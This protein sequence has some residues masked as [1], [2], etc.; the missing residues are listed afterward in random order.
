MATNRSRCWKLC[1]LVLLFFSVSSVLAQTPE[2]NDGP[3]TR[4]LKRLVAADPELKRLLVASIERARQVNPDRSTN[5]A[6]SLE[7]YYEFNLLGRA[8]FARRSAQAK[9]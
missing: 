6:Q 8:S 4:E 9:A 5:P 3:A 7:Q 1:A 2:S